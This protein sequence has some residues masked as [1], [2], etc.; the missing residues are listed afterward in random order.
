M[1]L[2]VMLLVLAV[3]VVVDNDGDP[4]PLVGNSARYIN[5]LRGFSLDIRSVLTGSSGRRTMGVDRNEDCLVLPLLKGTFGCWMSLD[6]RS[7]WIVASGMISIVSDVFLDSSG[8]PN[9]GFG[10]DVSLDRE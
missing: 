9:A 7:L 1:G 5:F 10:F 2:L 8:V 6:S 4:W 3:V